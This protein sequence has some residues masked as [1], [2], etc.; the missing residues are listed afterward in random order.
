M[1]ERRDG[2]RREEKGENQVVT[3]WEEEDEVGNCNAAGRGEDLSN[4]KLQDK[5]G[6]ARAVQQC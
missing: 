1:S 6:V 5:Q 3:E 2:W 4:G